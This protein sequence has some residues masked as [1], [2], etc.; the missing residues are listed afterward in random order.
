MGW[1]CGDD[2]WGGRE[3]ILAISVGI[4]SVCLGLGEGGKVRWS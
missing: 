2:G 3:G 4:V 1:A